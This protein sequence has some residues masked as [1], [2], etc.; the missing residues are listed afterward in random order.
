MWGGLE[1]GKEGV[2]FGGGVVFVGDVEK[3]GKEDCEMFVVHYNVSRWKF[4]ERL[5]IR[6]D[7]A[8]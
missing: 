1:K 3:I 8:F 7:V 5:H 6:M 2:F 4:S